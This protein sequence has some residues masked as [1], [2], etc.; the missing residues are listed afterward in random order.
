MKLKLFIK[1][2]EETKPTLEEF[3][4]AGLSSNDYSNWSFDIL[5]ENFEFYDGNVDQMVHCIDTIN[6]LPCFTQFGYIDDEAP[7]DHKI[8]AYHNGWGFYY[9]YNFMTDEI[10]LLDD[11]KRGPVLYVALNE[12]K[13]LDALFVFTEFICHC[14]KNG[15]RYDYDENKRLDYVKK[16]YEIA[17]GEKY[18]EFYSKLIS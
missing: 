4:K 16:A 1:K 6:F 3:I 2:V 18:Q 7:E 17:G 5:N 8:F 12:N 9:A 15:N 11:S 14:I 10:V 13:L